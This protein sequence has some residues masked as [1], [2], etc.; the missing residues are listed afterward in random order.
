MIW[1]SHL[2]KN[3]RGA[4]PAIVDLRSLLAQKFTGDTAF[5]LRSGKF[6]VQNFTGDTA[7]DLRLVSLFV[8]KHTGNTACDL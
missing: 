2:P 5:D 6:F 1:E 3:L 7:C 8:Q 4:L